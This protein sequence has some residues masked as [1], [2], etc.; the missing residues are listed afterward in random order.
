MN[1]VQKAQAWLEISAEACEAEQ[2]GIIT[3]LLAER[4]AFVELLED[5]IESDAQMG[6]ITDK[7]VQK[8][9]QLCEVEK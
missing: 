5:M 3:A 9:I 4:E 2:R 1:T 8:A 7:Q 6:R